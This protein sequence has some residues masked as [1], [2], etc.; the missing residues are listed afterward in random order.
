[1][2]TVARRDPQRHRRHAGRAGRPPRRAPRLPVP[3]VQRRR[4]RAAPKPPVAVEVARH[5]LVAFN[6]LGGFTH[7]GREYVITTTAERADAGAVGNVLANPWFGTVV[8]ESGGAYTWCENAHGYRLTPWHND[9]VSDAAARRSTSATRRR[10]LLV[11]DAAAGRRARCRTPPA[12]ASATASSSTTEDGIATRA[13]D[14]RRDRRAGEVR[15]PQAAQPLGPAAPAV[16]DRLLRA[17]ARRA[18]RGQPAARRH[19]GRPQDRRAASRA[20]P[21]TPSSASASRSSTAARRSAP[22]PAT[23]PSSSAATARLRSPACMRRAR[24]SGRVGAGL[25][26]CLAMQVTRRARR[27]PG[28]RGRVHVRLRPRPRRRA[29]A[30]PPLPRHRA[31]A[32]G[33]RGRVGVLEPHARR[34]PRADARRVAQLPGQRLAAL[35]GAGL[36][37]CGARSGFYQSGGAFGFRDQLQDAMALVHAEP[38]HP[39]RAAPALGGAPVPRRRRAALVA[40]AAAAAACARASPTTTSGCRTPP[41][42]TSPR[43]ATPACSTRRSQFLDGRPVK[44]DE[45]SYYDLPARSEESATRLRALRARDQARPALRRARPA[46]DGLRRLERRHE[47]RRRARQGRERLA[48]RSSSTTCCVS[49]ARSRAGAATTPFADAC[50]AEAA[51]LRA[52]HRAARAGTARGT[53]APTSTTASRSAR[54][55]APS[56]RSIRSRRAGRCSRG[57]GDPER[58]RAGAGGARRAPRAPRPRPHPAVRSAVRQ[59]A[60]EPRLHQGLRAR[61]ARERRPVHARRRLGGDGLRRRGRRRARLGAVPADQ[62]RPPRRQRQRRS[63]RTRSSRT[64]S[65]PTSTPT[66]S[67][68]AAA[69]GPGTPAR[70]AG[71]TA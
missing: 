5:D 47:P 15:R 48:R 4:G 14:L 7:D 39:A 22:S 62:P 67:T 28:A 32:R 27:R 45:D 36:P 35:P 42:A 24:L 52:E 69:A 18:P 12:T 20:T 9:P 34:G 17:G 16:A 65:P 59:V 56:A 33:A 13:V 26:P 37:A 50:A 57:A 11:A 71:C 51:T 31:G 55:R 60:P 8:S 64:S 54:R 21:T 38:A 66:R 44:P 68:P 70:P 43:S 40:S 53:A 3:R 19:R 58:A 61:R 6:G 49:S 1:M 10:P 63:R 46:A 25:D 23:A 29:H 2:Q 30:R 41:A